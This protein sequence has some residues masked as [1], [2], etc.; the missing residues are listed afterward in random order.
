MQ[1]KV[2][3]IFVSNISTNRTNNIFKS[4]IMIKYR[5]FIPICFKHRRHHLCEQ[6]IKTPFSLWIDSNHFYIRN[7]MSNFID[8]VFV[9]VVLEAAYR[10]IAI[11]AL[12]FTYCHLLHCS[13]IW[14]KLRWNLGCYQGKCCKKVHSSWQSHAQ[15][16][17]IEDILFYI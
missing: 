9:V 1:I 10:F 12:P 4:D 8:V 5:F 3:D 11:Y 13:T 7:V 14:Q 6:L 17:L 15:I 2:S 16:S